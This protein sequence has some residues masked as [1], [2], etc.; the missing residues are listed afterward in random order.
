MCRR[1]RNQAG[2]ALVTAIFLLVV[3]AALGAFMVNISTTQHSGS[4]LDVQGARA[5]QAA[6]AGVEWGAYQVLNPENS[7]PLGARAACP[8]TGALALGGSLSGF[9]VAVACSL[10][11]ATE[12]ARWVRVYQLTSTAHAGTPGGTDYVDRRVTAT[13]ATCREESDSGPRC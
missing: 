8:A 11:Q 7:D 6:R 5:Y 13:I 2:F 1:D 12:G 3:L 10:T 9:T 4:M